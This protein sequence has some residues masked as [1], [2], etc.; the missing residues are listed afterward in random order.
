MDL[1]ES[2]N[3]S[4][5]P[6]YNKIVNNVLNRLN[7][8]PGV[9]VIGS[10]KIHVVLGRKESNKLVHLINSDGA[11]FNKNVYSY[12]DLTPSN[13]LI[14]EIKSDNKPKAIKLQPDGKRL[15]FDY[16]KNIITVNVPPVDI[17]SIIEVEY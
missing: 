17:Y 15:K 14:I 11:H 10:E 7:P 13:S 8:V 16:Q 3:V 12:S 2:Y 9:R 4:R 6:I 5:H 1:S